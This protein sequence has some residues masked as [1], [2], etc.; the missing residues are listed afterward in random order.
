[1]AGTLTI[2]DGVAGSAGADGQEEKGVS[3]LRRGLDILRAFRAIDAPLSNKEISERTGLPKATVARLTYTLTRM[4]YLR[5]AGPSGQYHLGDKVSVLGHAL[6]RNLPVRAVAQPLM[7]TLADAHDTSVALGSGHG[8][9]MIYLSYCSSPQ[10]V[11]MRLRVGALVPMA[12]SAMGRAWLWALPPERRDGH[13]RLIET[14]AGRQAPQVLTRIEESFRQI[15]RDGFA[16]SFGDWRPQIYAVGAPVWLDHGQTV[17][18]LNCG[19]RRPDL[20]E[21][22]FRRT[23]GPALLSLASDISGATDLLG[24]TFWSE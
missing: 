23:L 16:V 22:F 18:A 20:S 19:A 8:T 13:L 2:D 12:L 9:Q 4:G 10:T 15:E 21:E 3:S 11:T 24:H 14:E 17:L 5:Q 7:Q 6:L 1:M